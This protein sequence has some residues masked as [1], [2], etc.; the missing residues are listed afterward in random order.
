MLESTRLA[1]C[2]AGELLQLFRTGQASPVEAARAV[3][4]RIARLNPSLN[5]FC[6]V[7]PDASLQAARDSKARWL[8]FRK[9]GA[10]CGELDGVPVSIKDLI[11]TRG[12]PFAVTAVNLAG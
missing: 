11:L 9:T 12:W 8:N 7:A 5:A 6:F 10:P 3:H 2:T 4:E 1:D